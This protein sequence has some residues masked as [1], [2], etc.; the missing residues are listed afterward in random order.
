LE[1]SQ[2]EER[3]GEMKRKTTLGEEETAEG[4]EE[5]QEEEGTGI[6]IY[7]HATLTSEEE[8]SSK[9]WALSNPQFPNTP[10]SNQQ[11]NGRNMWLIEG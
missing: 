5:D 8:G 10:T 3:E 6:I 4:K 2:L 7:V 1:T 9:L 11:F